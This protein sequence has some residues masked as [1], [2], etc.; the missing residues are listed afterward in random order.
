[1]IGKCPNCNII[2][3][4]EPFNNTRETN[5]V[6]V[7]LAYRKLMD[8]GKKPKNP[9]ELGYC[10]ICNSTLEDLEIQKNI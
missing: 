6:M 1:M 2:L 4:K 10:E 3:K 9:F 5:E 7:I 8:L